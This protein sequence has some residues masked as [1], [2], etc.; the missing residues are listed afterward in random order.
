MKIG[1]VLAALA[2]SCGGSRPLPAPDPCAG[3]TMELPSCS[4]GCTM[5]DIEQVLFKPK[6]V[7]CHGRVTLYPTTLDLESDGLAA[8]VVDQPA[9]DNPDKGKCAGKILVP[10][11]DP[12]GSIFVEK[13]ES[14]T[15]SC[16]IAMPQN[17][18][19][20][21][22]DEIACVKRW[23]LLAAQGTPPTR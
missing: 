14:L 19:P 22:A 2:V 1:V 6:C 13:V 5:A 18:P 17:A 3:S 9:E 23:A 15:P 21:G 16:G 11:Q 7:A 12:L 20:L 8:R 4:L 10:R